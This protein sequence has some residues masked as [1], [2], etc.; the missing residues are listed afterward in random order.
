MKLVYIPAGEFMM[1]SRDSAS[2]VARKHRGKKD[3]YTNELPQHKVQI[4]KGFYMGIYEV[5]QGQYRAIMGRNPSGFKGNDLP[6]EIVSWHDAVKFCE[7]L[8]QKEGKTYRLPTEAQWEYACRAGT[9]TPFYFGETIS[10]DQA[11]FY[12]TGVYGNGRKGVNRE[13]TTEVGSFPPNAFGL[14]DM[15]G[16]VEEW[17]QD[18]YD[19][20]YY[21]NSPEIDPEGANPPPPLNRSRRRAPVRPPKKGDKPKPGRVKRGG[22]FGHPAKLCRSSNRYKNRP[23]NRNICRGFRVVLDF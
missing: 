16:N 23:D 2:K 22:S 11:N 12:G 7:K 4:S 18:W 8:S 10:T 9:T 19:E 20:N 5:T 6:V 13:K 3:E 1:G 21:S 17:C 15:H 14:Y